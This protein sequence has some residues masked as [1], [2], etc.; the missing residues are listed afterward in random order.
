MLPYRR[1]VSTIEKLYLAFD[2]ARPP[3]ACELIVEGSGRIDARALEAAVARAA[4]VTPGACLRLSGHLGRKTWIVGPG[5]R[6]TV[7]RD[8]T[9]DARSGDGAPFLARPLDRHGPTCEVQLIESAARTFLIFRALHAVMDG[10]GT[11]MWAEAVMAALRGE[12]PAAHPS[13][14]TDTEFAAGITDE[15]MT[16]PPRD[17]LHPCG[18]ADATAGAGFQ[19]RRVTIAPPTDAPIV[20]T[21]AITLAR[22]ARRHDTGTVRFNVP[23]DL[24]GF[25]EEERSTGNVIGTLFV[26]VG[27]DATVA[28][29]AKDVKARLR[30]REHARFPARYEAL[31]WLPMGAFEAMVRRDFA[32]EHDTGRYSISATVSFLGAIEPAAMTA[33]G[34]TPITAFWPPPLAD[35]GCFV[36]VTRFRHHLE[37]VLGMP[38]ALGSHGRF[39]ALLAELARVVGR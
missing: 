25:H 36:V 29:V 17:A 22:E 12:A 6:V 4:A 18:R 38:R 24:R 32:R 15:P 30:A 33:P 16:L 37:L 3:F 5:P 11:R 2:R 8:A 20:A 10:L 34:F 27:P 21:L 7:V 28:D 9:W 39:D 1:P 35:Q 14:M 31:R 19:W 23:A 13:A 26:E